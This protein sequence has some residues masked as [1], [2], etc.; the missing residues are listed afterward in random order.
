MLTALAL[1]VELDR[2]AQAVAVER[3]GGVEV[4]GLDDEPEL[5]DTGS[6]GFGHTG[7]S[8]PRRSSVANASSRC[9][10][11]RRN[12][13]SQASTWASGPCDPASMA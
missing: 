3:H 2:Q 9:S 8:G 4:G 12:G 6:V 5:A 11:N 13:D 10:Q 1:H 7:E